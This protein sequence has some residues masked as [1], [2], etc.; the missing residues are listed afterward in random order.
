MLVVVAISIAWIPIIQNI[1]ELF[2]YIQ[3]ITSFLAPPVCAVYVLAILWKRINEQV[4]QEQTTPSLSDNHDNRSSNEKLITIR[5]V[6]MHDNKNNDS[7]DEI[8][9]IGI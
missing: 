4:I 3:A 8:K 9:T 2:H 1:S 7:D 6:I 5:V